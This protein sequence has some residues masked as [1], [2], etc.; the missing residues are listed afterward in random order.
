[1]IMSERQEKIGT[2]VVDALLDGENVILVGGNEGRLSETSISVV[3][4]SGDNRHALFMPRVL[5]QEYTMRNELICNESVLCFPYSNSTLTDVWAITGV[6][7]H[8]SRLSAI[9]PQ[10]EMETA[11]IDAWLNEELSGLLAIHGESAE[12]VVNRIYNDWKVN[13]EDTGD[14]VAK[15]LK[16][17]A[18]VSA[19]GKLSEIY[20]VGMKDGK[21]GV[22]RMD[23]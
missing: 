18:V 6:A 19:E 3:E 13:E 21:L 2:M 1:M 5:E 15:L 16:Y 8:M 22:E 9:C 14:F 11:V 10:E 12:R 23:V 20:T 17:V 7:R 4:L